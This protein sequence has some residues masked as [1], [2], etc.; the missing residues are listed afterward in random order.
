MDL[1]SQGIRLTCR[2]GLYRMGSAPWRGTART[3]RE[4]RSDSWKRAI[5]MGGEGHGSGRG[6]AKVSKGPEGVIVGMYWDIL[7]VS[8]H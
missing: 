8:F 2:L 3:L 5:Q 1:W 6:E 4:R 7:A